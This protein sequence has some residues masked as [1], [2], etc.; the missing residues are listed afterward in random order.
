MDQVTTMLGQSERF[1]LEL[2]ELDK[3]LWIDDFVLAYWRAFFELRID[4]F[5]FIFFTGR[6]YEKTASVVT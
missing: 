1:L 2:L 4:T 5:I 3:S 6:K